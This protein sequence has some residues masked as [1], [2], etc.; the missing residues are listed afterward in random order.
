MGIGETHAGRG[1]PIDPGRGD[2]R[3]AVVTPQI[4]IAQVIGQ[5]DHD[6]RPIGRLDCAG[7]DLWRERQCQD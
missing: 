4:A 5:H 7:G 2:S 3:L 6:V 1:Q